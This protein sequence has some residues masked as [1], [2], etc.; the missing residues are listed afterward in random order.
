MKVFYR[1][2]VFSVYSEVIGKFL[3]YRKMGIRKKSALIKILTFIG[4]NVSYDY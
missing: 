2:N 4:E 3:Y 1:K